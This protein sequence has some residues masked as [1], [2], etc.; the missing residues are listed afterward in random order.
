MGVVNF[1]NEKKISLPI[2]SLSTRKIIETSV[3][4]LGKKKFGDVNV[5]VLSPKEIQKL[6]LKY[7]SKDK[8]T[9][10]LSFPM[11]SDESLGDLYL[12]PSYI[13][14]SYKEFGHSLR[15]HYRMLLVHGVMHLY[16]F[17]HINDSD[18]KEMQKAENKAL[19]LLAKNNLL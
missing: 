12:C 19:K 11:G 17:D 1:I 5:V 13:K 18:F 9:D 4:S 16:D 10:I 15:Y 2:N 14:N 7:R 6:N 8:P 3:K